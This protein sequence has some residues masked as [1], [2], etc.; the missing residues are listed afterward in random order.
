MS[1]K[2]NVKSLRVYTVDYVYDAVHTETY[3]A[4]AGF[5]Y[6]NGRIYYIGHN[7]DNEIDQEAEEMTGVCQPSTLSDHNYVSDY[8]YGLN[9][10]EAGCRESEATNGYCIWY[11][12]KII[13]ERCKKFFQSIFEN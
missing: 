2:I 10:N 5:D 13:N 6:L 1:K 12:N 4:V 11:S 3:T 7:M 9:N 8:C